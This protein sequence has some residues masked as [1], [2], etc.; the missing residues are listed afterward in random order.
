MLVL[1]EPTTGLDYRQ[2]R[3]MMELLRRLN[4]AGHTIVIVTHS[5]W[6]AAEYAHRAVVL[7]RGGVLL[8]RPMREAMSRGDIL[9]QARLAPPQAVR[10]GAALGGVTLSVA[11]LK[12][13][14]A[15]P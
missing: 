12:Q 4:A 3:G 7:S 10:L 1:D 13:C 11:E 2:N 14:L 9:T 6:V 15:R 5:M 8:D